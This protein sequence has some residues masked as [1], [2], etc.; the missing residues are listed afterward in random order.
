MISLIYDSLLLSTYI[1]LVYDL[2]KC[3]TNCKIKI[4]FLCCVYLL[5]A[6][7]PIKSAPHKLFLK[8]EYTLCFSHFLII[9]LCNSLAN[10]WLSIVSLLMAPS[11]VLSKHL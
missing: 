3:I 9:G 11:L 10:C 4:E 2:L 1:F 5:T 6:Y 8:D 7:Q